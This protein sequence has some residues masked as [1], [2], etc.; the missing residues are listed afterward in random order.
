MRCDPDEN[1]ISRI[2]P[3]A[4]WVQMIGR[5]KVISLSMPNLLEQVR[6][7]NSHYVSITGSGVSPSILR[8][9]SLLQQSGAF[10]IVHAEGSSG[11]Q[12]LVLLK[13]TGLTPKSVP[14]LINRNAVINLKRCEGLNSQEYSSWLRSKFPHGYLQVTITG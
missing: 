1:S 2:P 8:V 7:S 14:T 5:C 6:Q 11:V 12:G 4:L 9:P 13:S 10:K 3:D